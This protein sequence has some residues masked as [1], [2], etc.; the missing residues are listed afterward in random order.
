MRSRVPVASIKHSGGRGKALRRHTH[1]SG[2]AILKAALE[3][4]WALSLLA[5]ALLFTASTVAE[6]GGNFA[7]V[8][9][10]K[11]VSIDVPRNWVVLSD[12]QRITLDTSVDSV[13]DLF[14]IEYDNTSELPFAANYYDDRGNII[15]I[16][17]VRYYPELDLSQADARSATI[18][19]VQGLD[20]AI[21]ENLLKE[22]EA[23][24]MSIRSW[25]GTAKSDINGIVTFITE[26][27]RASLQSYGDFRVKLVRVFAGDRSVTVTVSHL[28]SVAMMLQPIIDRIIASLRLTGIGPPT[29]VKSE[30]SSAMSALYGEHWPMALL[31][32]A[33]ITW[34]VGLA[35]PLLIRFVFV[36]RAIGK[37]WSIG[38]VGL[39][40]MFNVALF[41]ALGSQSKSHGPLALVALA[42]YGI[43]RKGSKKMSASTVVVPRSSSISGERGV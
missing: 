36:R 18:Q 40:W 13:L 33:L 1:R 20:A 28:S 9:L 8:T 42:S 4:A 5:V 22:M 43:L 39:F 10:P 17:N 34:G 35:P 23:F 26:Y 29:S 2:Y 12:N 31:V 15:A 6:A 37:G 32:S 38:L 14:G 27:R 41:A 25:S 21:K 24:G 7:T 11:G 3:Q 16:L 30:V 19:D